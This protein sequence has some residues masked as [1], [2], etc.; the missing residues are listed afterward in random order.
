MQAATTHPDGYTVY[1]WRITIRRRCTVKHI[2]CWSPGELC[3]DERVRVLWPGWQVVDVESAADYINPGAAG[4]GA[5]AAL[6]GSV[7]VRHG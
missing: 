1:R 6:P 3:I 7:E 2:H 4:I 5:G